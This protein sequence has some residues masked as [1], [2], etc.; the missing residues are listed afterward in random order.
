MSIESIVRPFST[1]LV[2]ATQRIEVLTTQVPPEVA[3]ITW[4]AGGTVAQPSADQVTKRPDG[5]INF[6][7]NDGS[8]NKKLTEF[9]RKSTPVRV[10]NPDDPSQYIMV[11]VPT[12]VGF[13]VTPPTPP[14]DKKGFG[15]HTEENVAYSTNASGYINDPDFTSNNPTTAADE[16]IF[17][18]SPGALTS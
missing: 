16:Y 14:A 8:G 15:T 17:N 2:I 4:G 13:Q 5:G 11:N 7:V 6:Q 10:Q 12:Q 1:P 3:I 9:V 18:F